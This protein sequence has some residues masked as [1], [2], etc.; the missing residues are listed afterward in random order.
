[1]RGLV[2]D[3]HQLPKLRDRL[4]YV[5]LEHVR[6][7]Q[8][9]T[10]IAA[11]DD[12]GATPIPVGAVAVLMLGPG[13]S[14]THAAIRALADNA[15]LVVWCGEENVRFYAFGAGGTESAAR[16]LHQARLVS[17]PVLRMQVVRRMY[18]FRFDEVPPADYTIEQLR[19]MEGRRVRDTYQQWSRATGV[20]WKGRRYDVHDFEAADPVNKALSAAN[21]CLYG[22]CHAAIVA[23]GYSPALGFIHTGTQR[24]FVLDLADLYKCEITIP[25]AFRVAALPLTVPIERA[26]RIACRDTF[27][28][29]KLLDR[30]LPDIDRIFGPLPADEA[31]DEAAV[32]NDPHEPHALWDP[33][34]EVEAQWL[35]E[36]QPEPDTPAAHPDAPPEPEAP[37]P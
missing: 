36:A 29:E 22:L 27:R 2:E 30:I 31:A 26:A 7:D 13:T 28:D 18:A 20:P 37:S 15:C 23:A 12:A 32:N 1:M 3:L 10:A 16:I 19:G 24:S 14:I 6:I 17:D 5:Y 4:S 34:P 25:L 33:D 35:A 8:H 9:D 21:A 11:W